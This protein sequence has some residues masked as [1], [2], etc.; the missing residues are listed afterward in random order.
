M[1]RVILTSLLLGVGLAMDACA[2]S[3]ANGLKYPKM[4]F[5]RIIL[6]AVMFGLFQGGMPLI[7]YFVGSAILTKIEWTI[8]IIALLLLLFVG[9][10]MIVEGKKCEDDCCCCNKDLTFKMILVQ[11]V[12]T[13]ID[14]LSVG[15]TIANYEVI[16][17]LICTGIVAVVTTLICLGAVY[18]GEKF[19]SKLGCKAQIL[20]GIILIGIGI[21]IF[22]SGMFF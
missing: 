15:F 17:A 10:R 22:I 14:A 6:I 12:A 20:G 2:V 4:K 13:S 19:G 8:P 18:I 9:I 11:A 16:E 7:G 5:S 1:L 3:M 21:E